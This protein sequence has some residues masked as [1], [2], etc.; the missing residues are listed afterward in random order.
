MSSRTAQERYADPSE[1]LEVLHSRLREVAPV[2]LPG[3]DVS[4]LKPADLL[5]RLVRAVRSSGDSGLH[6]L[7]FVAITGVFPSSSQVSTL[8]RDMSLRSEVTAIIGAL[9]STLGPASLP[10]A[11][12][13]RIDLVRDRLI[14][15][16]DFCARNEHNTGIQRVVR[17]T[18][19]VWANEG[20][21]FDIVAWTSDTT[22]YRR[23]TDRERD[24]VLNWNDRRFS[25][26][27]VV[28][29]PSEIAETI[30][31]PWQC[32]I[33]LP[34]VP[35]I[36]ACP[37]LGGIAEHSGNRVSAIG[38]DAIPL[39]SAEGQRDAES[40]RFAHYLTII[41]FSANVVA[42]SESAAEEF[43][44]FVDTLVSQG[45]TGPS[46]T[47]VSLAVEV[48]EGAKS[49]L[50][51]VERGGRPLVICVGSHEPRKNQ[52]AVLHAAEQLFNQ[53]LDFE[54]VFIGG[55]NAATLHDF[56]QRITALNRKGARISSHR[57]LG[58]SELWKLF[59]RARFSVFMSLHEGFGLP[60]AE[61][62]ALGTPVLTS[63]FGSLAEIARHGGC[64][65]VD[66]RD[67][68]AIVDA[69]RLMLTDDDLIARLVRE[70]AEMT[71]RTWRTYADELWGSAI[72][73]GATA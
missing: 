19:P 55:G 2:V 62:L 23:I 4:L 68:V 26:D 33:F 22:A 7:L 47:S 20:R 72:H 52:E 56:D 40:E 31:V 13:R 24:R 5:D 29:R 10:N 71:P 38:Y 18:L 58:D 8:K 32:Q 61:S 16:A 48:P 60:V 49:A 59:A 12:L 15:D 51:T 39:V 9:E 63:D 65:M 1:V 27:D 30:V 28:P 45:L 46:V 67:D 6:W 37:M 70:A 73:T 36:L 66:P 3:A 35:A 43:R 53:G 21:E 50:G 11:S 14:V 69:F 34:E 17:Q 64:V 41:K 44:G 57:R 54:L 42:I 25:P